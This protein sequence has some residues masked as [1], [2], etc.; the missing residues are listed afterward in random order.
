[1]KILHVT[2][3]LTGGAGVACKRIHEA[4]CRYGI[5]SS[6]LT[7]PDFIATGYAPS[8][9]PYRFWRKLSFY[10]EKFHHTANPILHSSGLVSTFDVEQLNRSDADIIH[11][12]WINDEFLSI[13]DI[14]RIRKPLVWTL[15][16]SWPFCGAEHHPNLPANDRRYAEGYS[17]RNFPA[18]SSGLDY[19]RYIWLYKR[20]Y[21]RSLNVAFVAP[22]NFE[23][24]LCRES[25]IGRRHSARRIPYP[26]DLDMFSTSGKTH[27]TST[28]RTI[29]FGACTLRDPNKGFGLLLEALKILKTKNTDF[30]IRLLC[31]GRGDP[32]LFRETGFPCD[33][34]GS[35]SA[36][37]ELAGIYRKADLFVCPSLVDNYPN[38]CLEALACGVPLAGFAEG[39]LTDMVT[40]GWNGSLATPY[41]PEDLAGKILYCLQNCDTLSMNA[42]K[43]AEKIC[44]PAEIAQQYV[45]LYEEVLRCK[46]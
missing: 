32:S 5:E 12:H 2:T 24:N 36:E 23:L 3:C 40:Q 11:L 4:L 35:I 37:T 10:L 15:H 42:R 44:N 16:D 1:M 46:K 17:R 34:S 39:G 18:T 22:S 26:L 21:W 20:F 29:C 45:S 13:R 43:T 33:S 14:A 9:L 31:F 27:R 28:E 38:T 7:K 41:D 25:A 19:D 8:V 6:I 30:K